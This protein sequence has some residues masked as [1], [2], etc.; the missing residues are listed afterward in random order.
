MSS[1]IDIYNIPLYYI[2]FKREKDLETHLTYRGFKDIH[3][4]NAID[5][6]KFIPKDL[7]NDG[8]LSIRGYNDLQEGREQDEGLPSLGAIG[9]TLSHMELWKKCIQQDLSHI[10]IAE[11][12][13]YLYDEI[14]PTDVKSIQEVL[15]HPKGIFVSAKINK[16]P[17]QFIGTHFYALGREACIELMDSVFPIDVQTDAYMAHM[18]NI[19]R[20]HIEGLPIARQKN[21]FRTSSIQNVCVKCMLPKRVWFYV[22]IVL[23]MI[24]VLAV[25]TIVY[26]KLVKCKKYSQNNFFI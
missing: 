25:L 21:G 14:S 20:V 10:L 15:K 9:C 16:K 22:I 2:S 1:T 11:Q 12:D 13:M 17:T 26:K 3:H 6:R 7:L 23:V 4:F 5:G 8:K 24:F 19:G 18:D